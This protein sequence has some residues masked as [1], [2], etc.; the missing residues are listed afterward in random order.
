ML[1]DQLSGKN[2]PMT[3]ALSLLLAGDTMIT[4]PWSHVVES[5]FVRL[6]EEIR[7]ADVAIANLET[8]IHEFKGYAQ[9]D[10]GGTHMASPPAIA[11]EMKWAGFNMLAH[12]N[13]H[14]FDYG[15][16]AILET[17]QHVERAGLVLAGSGSNLQQAG[18]PAYFRSNGG[19]VA[20]I[21][22]ASTFIAYGAASRSRPDLHGRP[23]LNP[24]RLTARERAIVVP[25]RTAE[26]IRALGRQIG[27]SPTKLEGRSF[28]LGVRFHVG[29]SFGVERSRQLEHID[30]DRNLEAIAEARAHAD[31]VV[32][33]IHAHVQ[34][35]WLR[36]FAYDAIDRGADIV[37]VHGPHRVGAVEVYDGKPI[38][39]SMGDFVYEPEAV[40]RLPVEA[41]ERAGLGDDS[42]PSDLVDLSRR[43][44]TGLRNDPR[45]FE[46]FVATIAI[47]GERV[48]R[49]RL[50]PVDLQF[51]GPELRRG[52]PQFAAL[53]MGKRIVETVAA[54]SRPYGTRIDY[55]EH[56]N[57]GV[58]NV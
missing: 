35:R 54:L 9:Q 21:A 58:I 8:V 14:A 52:R 28:K 2:R 48:T 42:S 17:L 5:A 55:D 56:E 43:R 29:K 53:E 45:V 49:I 32:A 34:G 57:C 31:I 27:R 1:L 11:A 39:Y 36:E 50:L 25:C 3:R 18:A 4:R 10:S 19:V 12:A 30:R 24:L 15:S 40:A 46:G 51:N 13:N 7:A 23:G 6:V 16:S 38:F 44:G 26:R 33:S 20:L 37:H 41:Y 22:M 47:N